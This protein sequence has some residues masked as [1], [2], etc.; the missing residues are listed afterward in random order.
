[1]AIALAPI[2]IFFLVYNFTSL[3]LSG[4]RLA[5][6]L[7]NMLYVYIGLSI[8]LL[9][10]NVGFVPAGKHFGD[11][12][13]SNPALLV[14]IGA[15][16][17]AVIVLAE[18]AVH[19][20]TKQVEDITGGTIKNRTILIVMCLSMAVAIGLS[21]LR[22]IFDIDLRWVLL[23][24]YGIA[25]TLMF[26]VPKIFTGI[27]FDSGG[28]ASG[29]MTAAFLLPLANGATYAIY[30]DR[31]NVSSFL[32]NDAFGVIALVAM[33]PLVTIQILG[34]V[35]K[36]RASMLEKERTEE[37]SMLLALEGDVIDME[38]YSLNNGEK[39]KNTKKSLGNKIKRKIKKGGR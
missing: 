32:M 39:N 26:F 15:L 28:V 9:G 14:G 31:P 19:V 8:F 2:T 4:K 30:G 21:M 36:L 25:L 7:F 20:L 17:G 12:L 6:T 3:K 10:A 22:I 13:A 1:M 18:P 29:A 33:T 37:F 27:A 24:G 35:Y 16:L 38:E 34:L 11:A 5:K 23:A